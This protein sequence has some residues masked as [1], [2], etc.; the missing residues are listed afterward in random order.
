MTFRRLSAKR[1]EP[2]A[3]I[4]TKHGKIIIID[5]LEWVGFQIFFNSMRLG[6]RNERRRWS[7]IGMRCVSVEARASTSAHQFYITYVPPD[8]FS[9][10]NDAKFGFCPDILTSQNKFFLVA[11]IPNQQPCCVSRRFP[12]SL[13]PVLM[14][15]FGCMMMYSDASRRQIAVSASRVIDEIVLRFLLRVCV[16]VE[17][18][19]AFPHNMNC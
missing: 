18:C 15:L 8:G 11:N 19:A 2:D 16:I 5:L 13:L 12:L 9:F 6:Q 7:V 10:A 3:Y 4:I 17:L 1:T 14:M